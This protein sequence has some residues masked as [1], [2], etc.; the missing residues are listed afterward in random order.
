MAG[1]SGAPLALVA[2]FLFELALQ[3]AAGH[4]VPAVFVF[5]D[6]TVDVG[7]NNF[8]TGCTVVCKA[9][10]PYYGVDY[11]H[12]LPTGR[13]SNGYNLADQIGMYVTRASVLKKLFRNLQML[14][15]FCY[16]LEKLNALIEHMKNL[17]YHLNGNVN[18]RIAY[19]FIFLFWRDVNLFS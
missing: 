13:F 15:V 19:T 17:C 7:N 2:L 18:T 16:L 6:S 12:H 9:N 1:R 14:L 3:G 11:P 8:L 5:G 10:H 4:L